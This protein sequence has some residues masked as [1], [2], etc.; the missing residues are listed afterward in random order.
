MDR[1]DWEI[2][3]RLRALF[4]ARSERTRS[5]KLGDYWADDRSLRLYDDFLAARIGWK[6]DAVLAELRTR[7]LLPGEV[8]TVLDWGCG[9]GIATRRFASESGLPSPPRAVLFDRS[10][11][12]VD[13]ALAR[14]REEG[15]EAEALGPEGEREADLLLVSHVLSELD[16]SGLNALLGLV[17]RVGR[18]LWVESG[19]RAAAR[20]LAAARDLLLPEMQPLAPCPHDAVCGTLAEGAEHQWCHHFATP[21]ALVF[22]DATWAEAA[23]RLG[24]DLRALPYA[25]LLMARRQQGGPPVAA[26]GPARL[27]GRPR[28]QRGLVRAHFC[29]REG[30]EEVEVLERTDRRAARALARGRSGPFFEI[31]VEGGRVARLEERP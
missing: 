7:G 8:A 31:E 21:P 15:I 30:V 18:V 29:R 5:E 6:W 14:C 3:A 16:E 12:A 17:R 28:A 1:G 20:R 10:P 27:L 11:R 26:P 9:T 22:Q 25:F 4:L 2:L 19:N 24:I 13:F 23:R